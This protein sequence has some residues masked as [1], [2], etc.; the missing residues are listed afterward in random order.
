MRNVGEMPVKLGMVSAQ[1]LTHLGNDQTKFARELK[2][3][4]GDFEG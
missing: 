4:L 2:H 1:D 3:K